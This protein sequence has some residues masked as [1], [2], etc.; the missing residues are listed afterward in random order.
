MCDSGL[1]LYS[2]ALEIIAATVTLMKLFTR[3]TVIELVSIG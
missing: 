2:R 3:E 1:A